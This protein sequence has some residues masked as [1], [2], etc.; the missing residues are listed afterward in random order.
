VLAD[1]ADELQ[2]D[3]ER[4]RLESGLD[5]IDLKSF[6]EKLK[7]VYRDLE[8]DHP[9]LQL[10][11]WRQAALLD[12]LQDPPKGVSFDLL[13]ADLSLGVVLNQA[14]RKLSSATD[15]AQ[16]KTIRQEV[17][18][19][20]EKVLSDALETAAQATSRLLGP[21][22]EDC[23]FWANLMLPVSS[24]YLDSSF[25]M[26]DP[27]GQRNKK[28]ADQ[29]WKHTSQELSKVLVVVAETSG[30]N[31]Y[32]G[33]WVP[34]YSDSVILSGSPTAYQKYEGSA[35]FKDDLPLFSKEI[36][37]LQVPQ[38]ILM[39]QVEALQDYMMYDF[40]ESL[41]VSLPFSLN[42]GKKVPAVFNIN[43]IPKG[44]PDG[45]RR[46]YHP[47]WLRETR[48]QIKSSLYQACEAFIL[49]CDSVEGNP[50]SCDW[51]YF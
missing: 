46:A 24:Q 40:E 35:V 37:M 41:F 3:V 49:K 14:R 26:G 48:D 17:R 25:F 21:K 16:E 31:S 39:L 47:V 11:L 19:V 36:Q 4:I 32:F 44:K 20:S 38:K 34:V 43:V 15:E 23:L 5:Y 8:N 29:L 50:L 28:R 13:E 42:S 9:R 45:W 2:A 6:V 33:F 18:Q 22:T 12:Y 27:T 30:K 51:D 10:W 7:E 1:S